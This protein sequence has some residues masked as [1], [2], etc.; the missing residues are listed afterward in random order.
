MLLWTTV[1]PQM[2]INKCPTGE[3]SWCFYSRAIA[4]NEV[5]ASHDKMIKTPIAEHVL[6]KIEP[7]YA[8]LSSDS[9]LEKCVT[10]K[11]QNANEALHQTIWAKCPKTVFVARKTVEMAA[12]Q[13]ICEY[14]T[15][16]LKS[17]TDLQKFSGVSPGKFTVKIAKKIDTKRL[18]TATKR[19]ETKYE[20]YR[21]KKKVA[22]L[23]EEERRRNYVWGRS[24]L[25]GV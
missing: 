14:N 2:I 15:G 24:F 11:T 6:K 23:L 17:V 16:R 3:T 20:E 1:P 25:S 5:P 13:A 22:M 9:L 7:I 19:K 18:K 21:K 4:K 12:G 10:G 8:R